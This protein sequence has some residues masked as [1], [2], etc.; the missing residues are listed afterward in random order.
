[1]TTSDLT[2]HRSTER[3]AELFAR[4]CRHLAGG[5]GSGTRSPRSGW[6]PHPI[7]VDTASGSRCIDV[8][9]NE[10]LDYQMGQGPLI[11]GHRPAPVIEAVTRTINERGSMFALCH[12]LEEAA[13]E[14]VCERIS[15]IEL[16]R[17]GNSGTECV[18]YALR[19]ARAFTGRTIVLRFEGAYHGWSDAIHWSAHP[20]LDE[21]GPVDAP[22]I[23]PSTS[24]IPPELGQTLLVLP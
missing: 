17:F 18:L 1:M 8:D 10:Y 22:G 14:A 20:S 21:A 9:G 3:S 4:A 15:S 19:F 5:V 24:G 13:A 6:Q 2:T 7:F 12:D 16:L 23:T 11:L